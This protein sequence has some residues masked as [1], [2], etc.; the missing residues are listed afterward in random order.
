M[1]A[2]WYEKTQ[3][4]RGT[5]LRVTIFDIF[6][7]LFVISAWYTGLNVKLQAYGAIYPG[8]V[9]QVLP[10]LPPVFASAIVTAILAALEPTFGR[11]RSSVGRGSGHVAPT[12]H[13][14]KVGGV[15]AVLT[16]CELFGGTVFLAMVGWSKSFVSALILKCCLLSLILS[17]VENV[18]RLDWCPCDSF[19]AFLR[20]WL[21]G[22][23]VA[24]DLAVSGFIFTF[25]SLPV[26]FDR[27][28]SSLCAGCSLHHLLIFRDVGHRVR[29]MVTFSDSFS[30]RSRAPS[31]GSG[32]GALLDPS[33]EP[34]AFGQA[35]PR[36][37]A[38][39]FDTDVVATTSLAGI[40]IPDSIGSTT[41]AKT[42]VECVAPAVLSG[43]RTPKAV[44]TLHVVADATSSTVAA[45]VASSTLTQALPPT[46]EERGRSVDSFEVD[47]SDGVVNAIASAAAK[48]AA[49]DHSGQ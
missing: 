35:A 2:A 39:H 27:I 49:P 24:R 17:C 23:R 31:I 22:H 21:Y 19:R 20:L 16:V 8:T 43:H 32:V 5:G 45:V 48:P 36:D 14:T 13:L 34:S 18:L 12:L 3:L 29:A 4:R 9:W 11:N 28:R 25:L 42:S 26:L 41:F 40:S 7:Y 10:K 47:L 33:A 37:A 38:A 44:A 46:A 15:C 30:D 6:Y 1:W